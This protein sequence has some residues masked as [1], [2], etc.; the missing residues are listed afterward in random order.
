MKSQFDGSKDET[1]E[2]NREY[3]IDKEG[4]HEH[5]ETDREQN[6][7]YDMIKKENICPVK[8]RKTQMVSQAK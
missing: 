6:S 4:N 7:E 1:K 8:K 3:D 5:H 2:G